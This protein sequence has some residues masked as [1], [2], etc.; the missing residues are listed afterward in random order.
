[1][2]VW[3][4]ALAGAPRAPL[5]VEASDRIDD[6]KKLIVMAFWLRGHTPQSDFS[7]HYNNEELSGE[8]TIQE[9]G[10]ESDATI[11]IT[12]HDSIDYTIVD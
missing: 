12:A 8:T 2:Q 4:T 5:L 3:I 11:F 10:I 1:M 7:L 6:V 9:L